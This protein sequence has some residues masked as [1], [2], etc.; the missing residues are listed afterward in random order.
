[1][2]R[3]S[4]VVRLGLSALLVW[5]VY[6]ETGPATTVLA[7]WLLVQVE[8]A[9]VLY[10]LQKARNEMLE[11]QIVLLVESLREALRVGS[12]KDQA[13]EREDRSRARALF[14]RERAH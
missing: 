14:S 3:L 11:G 7:V 12:L 13:R 6:W 5:F 4:T 9:T 10:R 8:C 1:M 2:A